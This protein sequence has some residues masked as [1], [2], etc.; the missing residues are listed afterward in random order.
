MRK[1]NLSNLNDRYGAVTFVIMGAGFPG[2]V[3]RLAGGGAANGLGA[4]AVAFCHSGAR[5]IG[6][7]GL[8]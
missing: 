2:L 5:T 8:L 4:V 1:M 7:E 6:L 3:V